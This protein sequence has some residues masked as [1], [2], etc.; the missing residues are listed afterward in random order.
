V[1]VSG[2]LKK[3]YSSSTRCEDDCATSAFHEAYHVL[4][5]AIVLRRL[6]AQIPRFV[7]MSA[8]AKTAVSTHSLNR[9]LAQATETRTLNTM[10]P[11]W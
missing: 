6:L 4:L 8:A 1:G 11:I 7:M 5:R 9:S 2:V 3:E 10:L